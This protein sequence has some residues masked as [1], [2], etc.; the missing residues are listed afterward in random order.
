MAV[1]YAGVTDHTN[2][3]SGGAVGVVATGYVA[4]IGVV[5][6]SG[7]PPPPNTGYICA[8]DGSRIETESADNL[9]TQT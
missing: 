3:S 5:L 9:I 7:G 8:Q 6:G 4:G 1:G 2:T